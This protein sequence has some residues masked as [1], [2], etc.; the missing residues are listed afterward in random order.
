MIDSNN[1]FK[2]LSHS[3]INSVRDVMEATKEGGIPKTDKHKDLAAKAPPHDKITHADVLVGRGVLKKHPTTGKLVTKE[4]VEEID[5]LSEPTVRNY[6]NKAGE[7]G[8]KIADKMKIGGGDWTADGSDTKTLRKRAAGRDMAL[9]RRRGEIKMSEE[10]EEIDEIA[11]IGKAYKIPLSSPKP[12]GDDGKVYKEKPVD[13]KKMTAIGRKIG[14]TRRLAKEEVEEIDEL[15]GSTLKS[16]ISKSENNIRYNFNRTKKG[17]YDPDSISPEKDAFHSNEV[18]KRKIGRDMAF[19]KLAGRLASFKKEE[20][21][22][23]DEL[24]RKTLGSYVKKASTSAAN[25]ASEYGTK[26]AEADEMDRMMNRHM[27]YSDKDKVRDIMK[28]NVKDYEKPREKAGRRIKGINRAVDKLTREG[29]GLDLARAVLNNIRNEIAEGVEGIDEALDAAARYEQHHV[30]IKDLLKSIDQ[31]VRIHKAEALK[32]VDY[33]GKKSGVHWGH[34][35]DIS[36]VHTA[37]AD[38]HDRLAQQGEYKKSMSESTDQLKKDMG[39]KTYWF[40]TRRMAAKHIDKLDALS[41]GP[42]GPGQHLE[43][44]EN[45]GHPEHVIGV[46]AGLPNGNATYNHLMK[47]AKPYNPKV[48][49]EDVDIQEIKTTQDIIRRVAR[50]ADKL[51]DLQKRAGIAGKVDPDGFKRVTSERKMKEDVDQIDELS[52]KTLGSYIKKATGGMGGVADHAYAAGSG[53][54]KGF[55]KAVKRI[56]G[57]E[58]AVDKMTSESVDEAYDAAATDRYRKAFGPGGTVQQKRNAMNWL[59]AKD[60]ND[61]AKARTPEQHKKRYQEYLDLAKKGKT[62]GNRTLHS[63]ATNAAASYKIFHDLKEDLDQIDEARGR[64]RKNPLPPGKNADPNEVEAR[65]HIIQQLER[66]KLSMRGGEPVT[67]MDGTKH[68]VHSPDA[69][70][71]IMKYHSMKPYEKEIFQKKIHASHAGLKA[72]L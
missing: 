30:A 61:E 63:L 49:K 46:H 17:T 11:K 71:I 1:Q 68:T 13:P 10:V 41:S 48:T 70:K 19:N 33:R 56:K 65:M 8:K 52:K 2:K 72:E 6:Y 36:Q 22:E 3:L 58:K 45:H 64:P 5:E 66:A 9:K 39:G 31:H 35:G 42:M 62:E 44:G 24:S 59:D 18:R 27:S 43:Y 32:H 29:S 4:E 28:T 67:F 38:I 20:V 47:Y 40:S 55:G 53:R 26:K 34:V 51:A 37:L 57:V 25:K 15:R 69:N 54:T 7:Q 60:T 21:E 23:I 12:F 50:N 16:Y 14:D